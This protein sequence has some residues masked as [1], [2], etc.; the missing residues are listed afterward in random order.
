MRTCI[1]ILCCFILRPGLQSQ[2]PWSVADAHSR[3]EA[4]LYEHIPDPVAS[5]NVCDSLVAFYERA[6]DSC[7]LIVAQ[8]IRAIQYGQIS[9]FLRAEE[10]MLVAEQLL[11]QYSC[12]LYTHLLLQWAMSHVWAE[13]GDKAKADSLSRV[14][15]NA[16][17]AA[18][19]DKRLLIKLYLNYGLTNVDWRSSLNCLDTAYFLARTNK[20][21][22][23]QMNALLGLGSNY[24]MRDSVEMAKKY[25]LQALA[26]AREQKVY[27][28]I[29]I[30]YN[31]L[32]GISDDRHQILNYLDS[33][34][35]YA[36]ILHNLSAKQKLNQNKALFLTS[37]G[38]YKNGYDALWWAYYLQDTV[39]SIEKYKAITE[40]QEKY[41]A[42]KKTNEIQSLKLDNLDKE[43]QAL[44]YKRS[45]NRFLLGGLFSLSLSALLGYGFVI[46]R[47][48]RS[49]LAVEKD[50]SDNLLL[51][52]LPS[53]IA[54]E[55]KAKGYSDARDYEQVSILFSDFKG[56]TETS[57][58]L[59]A[60]ALVQ[61]IGQCFEAFDGIVENYGI[62]KIKTIG[63]AYMAAGGLP[64]LE[65]DAVK[66]TVLAA[67][68]MQAF[69]LKRKSENE[70]QSKPAFEMRS[71]INTGPVVA[72]IVGVKKFQYDIWG[73]TVNTA[74]RMESA[75]EVGKVNISS[76]T[77]EAIKDQPGF[78]FTYR[79]KVEAKGKGAIDMW[80]VEKG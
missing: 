22:F 46:I 49:Q 80:F 43:F 32:A 30:L 19:P 68:D 21:P 64:I 41:E 55:L 71:G 52:I 16:Y 74:S 10:N 35:L 70:A 40:M 79:G 75:G 61:E 15:I 28:N 50:R 67:L 48:S 77:Y 13:M 65:Q 78:V 53:E 44:K 51:N 18:W 24:A 76:T 1:I 3:I 39:L 47:R 23:Y 20:L 36:D 4:L 2:A 66:R 26:L 72:G 7:G 11:D 6:Q 29:L 69:I 37:L 54:E 73:D 34:I 42:E 59:S 17:P 31:N 8:T 58:G 5:I 38:D 27:D 63:D 56:F 62:E 9:K 57:S 60:V 25:L 14:A 33:A 45:K 12:D